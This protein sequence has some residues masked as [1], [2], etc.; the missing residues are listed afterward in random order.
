MDRFSPLLVWKLLAAVTLIALG[1][2]Y[3]NDPM[4]EVMERRDAKLS[5]YLDKVKFDAGQTGILFFGNSLMNDALAANRSAFNRSLASQFQKAS[6]AVDSVSIVEIATGGIG[7]PRLK[8]LSGKLIKAKPAILV[9]QCEMFVQRSRP[10]GDP[11]AQQFRTR[12]A[13]WSGILQLR[14]LGERVAEKRK[15]P[16]KQDFLEI[17]KRSEDFEKI[18]KER[19]ER[20]LL[21]AEEM[22]EDQIASIH[23][24]VFVTGRQLVEQFEK[25]GIEVVVIELPVSETAAKFAG[26]G[27][28]E[29]RTAVLRE[30]M[31]SGAVVMSFPRLLNDDHFKDYRHLNRK[32]RQEF[33]R[34]LVPNLAGQPILQK[35]AKDTK[36][37]K[38]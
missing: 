8:A 4:R 1:F 15:E 5:A 29:K 27:Y 2:F 16:A 34:W 30:L 3:V 32:G 7:P 18:R 23:S 11:A 28:L 12:L 24:P 19:N 13:T 10:E 22:W 9:I 26:P 38:D 36:N 25:S 6:V 37:G 20:D 35:D 31:K 17:K 14:F 21:I 33:L